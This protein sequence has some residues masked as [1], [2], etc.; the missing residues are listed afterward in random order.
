MPTTSSRTST[1]AD[2]ALLR[3]EDWPRRIL[4][5]RPLRV[6]D[7][8]SGAGGMSLGAFLAARDLGRPF[9]IALSVEKDPVVSA[10][11]HHNFLPFLTTAERERTSGEEVQCSIEEFFPGPLEG[12]LRPEEEAMREH[13]GEV[14]LLM[15]GPPCQGNSNL[16]NSTRRDDVR[17]SLYER[18]A[19]AA[20][21]L[22]P[23][24]VLIENVPPVVH[25]K[26]GHVDRV[27]KVLECKGY[28]IE[29]ILVHFDCL[30]VP[31]ARKR[32]LLLASRNEGFDLKQVADS[33]SSGS[34][35]RRGVRWAIGDLTGA[36]EP[37]GTG[38][39]DAPPVPSDENRVRMSYF[40]SRAGRDAHVLPDELRPSC[41][42]D[43]KHSYVSIYGRLRW[44]APSNTVTTGYGSMGQGCY[45]HPDGERTITPREAARLQTFPD[46][47]S[48]DAVTTKRTKWAMAIGNAVPPLGMREV[49][50]ALMG[51]V[52]R[53]RR[54]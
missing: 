42:R 4:K 5:G 44:D 38:T 51:G 12:K 13:C 50:K 47:F 37:E 36:N 52:G 54:S 41:H 24:A 10:I 16:N 45:V 35:L 18:M 39:F 3:R 14:D 34:D 17:N 19:R 30:G 33:L 15:G 29:R 8:F 26:G 11:H 23:R 25:A 6:V 27:A 53:S 49:V 2:Q 7:L 9:E 1:D 28:R 48:F 21:V 46:F 32:H 43:K 40:T 31:Q 20:V 22:W